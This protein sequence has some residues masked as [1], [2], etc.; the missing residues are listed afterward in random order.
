[1]TIRRQWLI[2]LTITAVLA[3]SINSL[4]LNSLTNQY[5]LSYNSETYNYHVNQIKQIAVNALSD[6]SYTRQ[7]LSV[8]LES[9]LDDPIISIRLYDA[10]GALIA[11]AQ[12]VSGSGYGMMNGMMSRMMHA[13]SEEVDSY[14]ISVGGAVTGVLHI[15]RYSSLSQSVVATRFRYALI[16]NS[17]LSFLIVL[18]VLSLIG[19]FVSKKLGRD[20]TDTSTLAMQIDMGE[21]PHYEPSRVREIRIIQT[22]LEE[23]QNQLR[24]RQKGR[25]RVIDEFVHQTRTPLSILRMHLEGLGDGIITMSGEE[26]KV[27]QTQIDDLSAIISN[28][29][30]LLDADRPL[31]EVKAEEFDLHTLLQ[32]II[33]GMK[34]AYDKKKIDLKMK[35]SGK[36][37]I[38]ADKYKL[39][40]SI[41][42][43]LANAYKFT[44]PYG[45]VTVAYEW[46]DDSEV[47]IHIRDS[48]TGIAKEDIPRLFE[49]YYRGK[50]AEEVAGDGLG[51]YV[52]KE[53]VEQMGGT[54]A[55]HS[56]QGVGSE[57]VLT[58]PVQCPADC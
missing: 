38:T 33:N 40:Q 17:L 35:N 20:L 24:I 13:N 31:Q 51:L 11:S 54:I 49:A 52:V 2:I 30:M 4:I 53:N 47:S 41:Y 36:A 1:M 5:F 18:S 55:V 25:K 7:Q 32:Q 14:E 9:H 6:D 48:G 26:I 8:Q 21:R 23:L 43:L 44:Q 39:S 56:D 29:S 45:N 34:V 57:F 22:R 16:R 58:I 27:C 42:N 15:I 37:V 12:N 19:I 50:N 10:N 3:V 46:T 28:M